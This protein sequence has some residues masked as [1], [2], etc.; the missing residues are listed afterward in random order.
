VAY[1]CDSCGG[2]LDFD[3]D[4]SDPGPELSCPHAVECEHPGCMAQGC[5]DAAP[6]PCGL[7]AFQFCADHL[8]TWGDDE[9][10]L[11]CWKTL[12]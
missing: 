9:F 4:P 8:T 6:R 7:C 12:Q 1:S 3:W 11:A 2:K 5:G 10:C